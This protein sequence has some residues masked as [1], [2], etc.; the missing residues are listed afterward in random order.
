MHRPRAGRPAE[1]P[2]PGA[3]DGLSWL[4][5][6]LLL[7][8]ALGAVPAG[9]SAPG[10]ATSLM[11]AASALFLMAI[12]V[13]LGAAI[14]SLGAARSM[15]ID[16]RAREQPGGWPTYS[17]LVALYR[18]AAVADQ[19]L[20][21]MAAL[22]Y[23]PERLEILFL[24]ESDDPETAL[25]LAP[26]LPA[27][28]RLVIVPDGEPRT[29][30]RALNHGLAQATGTYLTVF[31][32]EDIPDPDQLKQAVMLF[33]QASPRLQCLQGRLCIDNLA[34]G[35]LPLMMAIEYMALFDSLK[36][37][38]ARAGLPVPLG[39]TSNHFRRADLVALGGWDPWN[40][41]EDADLGL[42]IARRG[43]LVRDLDSTTYEEAPIDLDG[44]LRQRRRWF[45]GWLQTAAVNAR[46]PRATIGRMGL[47]PWLVGQIGVLGLVL[48]ALF[49]P[50][51]SAWIAWN[52]WT[53]DLF[54]AE[55]PL[56]LA[57]NSVAIVV[58]GTGGLTMAAPALIGLRRRRLWHLAPWL[59]TL[60]LYLLLVSCAAWMAVWDLNR[61]PFQWHKTE[62]G[63][64]RRNLDL[65][66]S[67]R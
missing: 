38:L 20:R 48:S 24:L 15:P 63:R 26:G 14:E 22:D 9:L 53:G 21:A 18:E 13:L 29:K 46:R 43:G 2:E 59:I 6:A 35:W 62:H 16:G 56:A 31:D 32:A 17:I 65:F 51:F 45:K 44:W 10:A 25:A 61:R 57:A 36:C 54:D 47:T 49:F 67:R 55:T 41:A 66:R 33:E 3:R 52:Y 1:P 40:V 12:A 8:L 11:L 30:P 58:V 27:H 50:F 39:G 23:P 42:R 19:L 5:K 7:T 64:G 34:D 28:A 60:P 37:G 4:Q